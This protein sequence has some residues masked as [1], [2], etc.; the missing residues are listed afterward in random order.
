[1]IHSVNPPPKWTHPSNQYN[2]KGVHCLTHQSLGSSDYILTSV[3][4]KRE[5]YGL[6]TYYNGLNVCMLLRDRLHQN[7]MHMIANHFLWNNYSNTN[8]CTLVVAQANDSTTTSTREL[9]D[10]EVTGWEQF[11]AT[12]QSQVNYKSRFCQMWSKWRTEKDRVSGSDG[13]VITCNATD[14]SCKS[15]S[16]FISSNSVGNHRQSG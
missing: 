11:A 5:A 13:R 10:S 4:D 2:L 8:T 9:Q 1:M 12:I 15:A 7:I 3:T 16:H 6:S 14:F